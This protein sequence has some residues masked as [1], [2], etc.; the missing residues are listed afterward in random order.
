MDKPTENVSNLHRHLL[1]LRPKKRGRF[2]VFDEWIARLPITSGAKLSYASL[3]SFKNAGMRTRAKD[4]VA[5]SERS[6]RSYRRHLIEME[7]AGLIVR[8]AQ[9]RGGR[10]LENHYDLLWHP[11][12]P[13]E[14]K[15]ATYAPG[16]TPRADTHDTTMADTVDPVG[17]TPATARIK[18]ARELK[19][20]AGKSPSVDVDFELP[21]A[22]AEALRSVV[23]EHA[24]DCLRVVREACADLPPDRAR[25]VMVNSLNR[26]V[27]RYEREPPANPPG[28]LRACIVPDAITAETAASDEAVRLR[29]EL[30][31]SDAMLVN[32][33]S[34][35]EILRR[36]RKRELAVNAYVA[37][38]GGAMAVD[39]ED[40]PALSIDEP[41]LAELLTDVQRL[42]RQVR[43][44]RD[45]GDALAVNRIQDDLDRL[46]RRLDQFLQKRRDRVS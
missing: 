33:R 30:R 8:R 43:K 45:V 16:V 38:F 19:D 10:R 24:P 9:F 31:R 46:E 29:D 26:L 18:N 37:H 13:V 15:G 41:E 42:Q 35:F 25:R 12:M 2:I 6:T 20:Q 36:M 4:L 27:H 17:L 7:A 1:I 28:L 44:A 39:T 23:K 5:I 32:A 21:P 11:A 40:I 34:G 14:L 3:V 22:V